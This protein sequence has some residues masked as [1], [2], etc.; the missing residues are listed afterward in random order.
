MGYFPSRLSQTFMISCLFSEGHV[1]DETLVI[2][3]QNYLSNEERQCIEKMLQEYKEENEEDLLAHII[4][5]RNP[6]KILFFQYYRNLDIR[7]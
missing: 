2:S 6:V 3:F 1:T 4:A 5:S 7:S